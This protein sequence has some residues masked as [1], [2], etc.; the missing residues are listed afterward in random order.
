MPTFFSILFWRGDFFFNALFCKLFF[1]ESDITCIITVVGA[2]QQH[3][4][5]FLKHGVGGGEGQKFSN[6]VMG[7][8]IFFPHN[9]EEGGFCFCLSILPN[10]PPLPLPA[11]HNERSLRFTTCYLTVVGLSTT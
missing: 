8:A 6:S 7:G 5:M 3:K 1:R 9:H 10:H 4:D 2:Q 11:I